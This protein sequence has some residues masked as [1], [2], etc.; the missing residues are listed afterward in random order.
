MCF[1]ATLKQ[2]NETKKE[3]ERREANVVRTNEMAG[4]HSEFSLC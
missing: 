1:A 2:T 3:D 4:R